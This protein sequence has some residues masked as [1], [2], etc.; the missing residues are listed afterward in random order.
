MGDSMKRREI[1]IAVVLA[2]LLTLITI[3]RSDG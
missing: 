2:R 3:C 1:V